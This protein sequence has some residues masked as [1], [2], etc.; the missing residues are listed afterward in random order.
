MKSLWPIGTNKRSHPNYKAVISRWVPY[1][2]RQILAQDI[3]PDHNNVDAIALRAIR[4][5][6]AVEI[7]DEDIKSAFFHTLEYLEHVYGYHRIKD[8][9]EI[10]FAALTMIRKINDQDIAYLPKQ[11]GHAYLDI[12]IGALIEQEANIKGVY[13]NQPVQINIRRKSAS[14]ELCDALYAARAMQKFKLSE[15]EAKMIAVV[16]VDMRLQAMEEI[17]KQILYQSETLAHFVDEIEKLKLKDFQFQQALFV[18]TYKSR[19]LPSGILEIDDTHKEHI[20]PE[21]KQNPE[22][23]GE[24][25]YDSN[26]INVEDDVMVDLYKLISEDNS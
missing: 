15:E 17:G 22:S 10:V 8:A 6:K 11:Y 13:N 14:V 26:N 9:E 12:F 3:N 23:K 5:A 18:M 1:H 2:D 20:L 4:Y 25:I 7:E 19:Y 24:D 16:H 21:N